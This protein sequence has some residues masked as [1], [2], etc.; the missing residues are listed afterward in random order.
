M[1]KVKE[2]EDTDAKRLNDEEFIFSLAATTY[3]PFRVQAKL[4]GLAAANIDRLNRK[5]QF[6][7]R[8]GEPENG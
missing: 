8:R 7:H 5:Q 2:Y 1:S 4:L 6:L 3:S